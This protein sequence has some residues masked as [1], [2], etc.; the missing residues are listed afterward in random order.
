MIDVHSRTRDL[1]QD[2]SD[3]PRAALA[4][5]ANLQLDRL[6]HFFVL[7]LYICKWDRKKES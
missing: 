1:A 4:S 7:Y 6:S 2:A 3:G 5:H